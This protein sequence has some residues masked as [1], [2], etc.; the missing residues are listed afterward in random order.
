MQQSGHYAITARRDNVF[1][2]GWKIDAGIGMKYVQHNTMLEGLG[3][4]RTYEKDTYD[5]DQ[6]D[7]Y[8]LDASQINRWLWFADFGVTLRW[9]KTSFFYR[10]YFHKIEYKVDPVDLCSPEIQALINDP[11]EQEFFEKTIQPEF[12]S[13]WKRGYYGYGTIGFA[14]FFD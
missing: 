6:E 1:Q 12:D 8:K 3:T 4:W 7:Y 11:D 13:N 14:W 2:F 9:R 5:I 10:Q